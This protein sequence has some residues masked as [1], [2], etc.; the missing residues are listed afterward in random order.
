MKFSTRFAT[1]VAPHHRTPTDRVSQGG[2]LKAFSLG[3]LCRI[4]FAA[5]S[6]KTTVDS[7]CVQQLAT[8]H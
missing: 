4:V 7:E 8:D 2:D 1:K 3:K 6:P 5:A